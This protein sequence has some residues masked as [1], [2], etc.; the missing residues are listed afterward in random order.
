M[1]DR[2]ITMPSSQVVNPGWLWP[3]PR[4]ATSSS[5]SRAKRTAA[6]TSSTP[7]QRATTAGWPSA[8]AF[9]TARAR[10]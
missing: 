7:A 3:P 6:T 9:Q 4:T 2:S 8:V 5:W 10:S 1:G